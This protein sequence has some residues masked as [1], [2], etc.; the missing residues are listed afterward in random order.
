MPPAGRRQSAS[1]D[2]GRKGKLTVAMECTDAILV[3]RTLVG[4]K[5]AYDVLVDRYYR[6]VYSVA[7][8][9]LGNCDDARDIVQDAFVRAYNSLERFRSDANF[10]TWLF[11]IASNLCIDLMRSRRS[12]PAG[13]LDEE[14]ENGHE[15]AAARQFQPEDV[16]IQG[17]VSEVVQQAILELPERYRR[18]VILRHM[19]GMSIDEIAEMLSIPSGTVKTHLYRARAILRDRLGPVLE[20]EADGSV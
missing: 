11:K 8:R 7:Y 19:V 2:W 16:V 10:Q 14:M 4:D 9:M 5:R 1:D 13:S 12:K 18:A 3:R 17:A 6:P 20:M 15:P